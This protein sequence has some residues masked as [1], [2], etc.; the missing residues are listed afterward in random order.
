MRI[1]V[2]LE[3]SSPYH[4]T[5]K[6]I[7]KDIRKSED[8]IGYSY[9]YTIKSIEVKRDFIVTCRK[10]KFWFP[11]GEWGHYCENGKDYTL[12]KGICSLDNIERREDFYCSNGEV[13]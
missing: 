11:S 7:E 8:E 9:D 13:N 10:C 4:L 1:I 5:D 6:E 2:E 12:E 3:L